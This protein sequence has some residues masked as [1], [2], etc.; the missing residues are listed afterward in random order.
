MARIKIGE[1]EMTASLTHAG[2]TLGLAFEKARIEEIAALLDEEAAP[3]IREIGADGA[4]KAVYKN[5]ALTRVYTETV[6][7]VRRVHAVM[8][9]TVIEQKEAEALR[10]QLEAAKKEIEAVKEENALLTECV[11]EMS[12][13]VYQ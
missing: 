4:T 6:G 8:Q 13:V 5:H 11:L 10:E 9:T 12:E 3:E 7:G 1:M 2:G